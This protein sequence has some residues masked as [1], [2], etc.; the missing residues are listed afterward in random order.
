MNR[1]LI[2]TLFLAAPFLAAVDSH[3]APG[4]ELPAPN[5]TESFDQTILTNLLQD[6][7]KRAHAALQE[8][9]EIDGALPQ[10]GQTQGQAGEFRLKLFPQGKSRSQEHVTA[11]GSFRLSPDPGQQE[12]TLHFKSSTGPQ[13][14]QPNDDII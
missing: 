11:E 13:A 8:Y 7:Y 1:W 3:A 6:L 12:F 9:V 2:V 5:A 4:E 10:E 14:P